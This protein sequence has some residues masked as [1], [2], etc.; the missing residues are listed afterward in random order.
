MITENAMFK[1]TDGQY[2]YSVGQV[3]PEKDQ[4][5]LTILSPDLETIRSKTYSMSYFMEQLDNGIVTRYEK[6]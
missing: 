1:T 6:V 2:I 4:M 5:E 3:Y